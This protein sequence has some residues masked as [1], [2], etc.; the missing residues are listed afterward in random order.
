MKLL[1]GMSAGRQ[2]GFSLVELMVALSLSLLLMAGALSILY[3]S[4][5]S[6]TENDRIARL[7]E[8]GR[9]VVEL[10]LRDSRPAGYQGCSRPVF[11]DEFSNG[12]NGA[13]TL[14]W[15]FAEPV[16]GF[17]AV[18]AGWSPGLN[19]LITP[20]ATEGSD[21][22]ALRTTRQ[23]QPL[24]RTNA[25]VT[26]MADPIEVDRD[27]GATVPANTPMIITD[28]E[29]AAVFMATTFVPGVDDVTAEIEHVTGG[30]PGNVSDNLA[31]GFDVG[32]LVMPVE[33]IIYYVRPSATGAGPSLWQRVGNAAPQELIEGVENLQVTYGVDTDGDQLANAYV[34]AS[35]GL[36][37]R[38][39]LSISI[40]VL[41][42]SQEESGVERDNRTYTLL[43]EPPLGPFN[44]R[45]LRS[46]F[47]TTVVLRNRTS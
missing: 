45:R 35:P 36:D 29:G 34:P 38:Q 24:F 43:D 8:A 18:G 26:N 25:P 46:V 1:S 37:W 20:L 27:A 23:G 33:T 4:R 17:N 42:R 19:A 2:R 14:L 39:V 9:T 15:N 6:Y 44:D 32:A 30:L 10:M 12:L 3:S 7:Q 31:R 47:T 16:A 11:G 28:C 22:L 41:I 21:V 13:A 40:A 5:L